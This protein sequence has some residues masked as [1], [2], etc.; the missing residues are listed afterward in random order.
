[1]WECLLPHSYDSALMFGLLGNFTSV[2]CAVGF[3]A[4]W[5]D[6]GFLGE[7]GVWGFRALFDWIVE[8]EA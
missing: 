1:L 4:F 2:V 6:L 7:L 8:E 5:G 3:D